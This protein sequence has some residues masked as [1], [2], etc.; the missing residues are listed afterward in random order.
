MDKHITYLNTASIGI[1][2]E[3]TLEK[4]Y[5]LFQE[6]YS[7]PSIETKYEDD[8]V[9]IKTR[10]KKIL[11]I[12]SGAL[13]LLRNT[14]EGLRLI[15]KNLITEDNSEVILTSIDHRSAVNYWIDRS[16]NNKDISI[17]RV[18]IKYNY[19]DDDIVEEIFKS[20]TNKTSVIAVPHI[21][22]YFGIKFPVEMICSK[23]RNMGIKTVIDGSQSYGLI[24][25]DIDKI[26][27][28]AY[29][30]C[31]HKWG[32]LPMTLGFIYVTNEL[33]SEL[34]RPFLSGYRYYE[35][36]IYERDFGGTELGTRNVVIEKLLEYVIEENLKIDTKFNVREYAAEQLNK[37]NFIN[38]YY[39]R[40]Y[41]YPI[42][43]L[44]F[45]LINKNTE[46]LVKFLK[47]KNIIVGTSL[48]DGILYVR[49]SIDKKNTKED[50]DK[51]INEIKRFINQG[52]V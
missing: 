18:N 51:L 34:K 16:E 39:P 44:T 27:P 12:N 15:S 5:E 47:D 29:I 3:S 30:G 25:I 13:S 50:I 40:D 11:N 7:N 24:N 49:I 26:D 6:F 36:S 2:E 9:K 42:G 20:V 52:G 14:T 43:I 1:P 19:T 48:V 37:L 33:F 8:I 38:T 17:K 46:E 28:D 31:F 35:K 22:R 41:S 23:A 45:K 4:M 21:D 10:L 32:L